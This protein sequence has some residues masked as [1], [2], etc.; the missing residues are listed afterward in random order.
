V[1]DSFGVFT[2]L[3]DVVPPGRAGVSQF[4]LEAVSSKNEQVTMIKR[5]VPK[6]QSI[7]SMRPGC[8]SHQRTR[9]R[10]LSVEV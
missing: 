4:K 8:S 7:N 5:M 3:L 10:G 2:E 9:S 6:I 1:P